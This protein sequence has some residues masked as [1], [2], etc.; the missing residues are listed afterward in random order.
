MCLI[1]CRYMQLIIFKRPKLLS[2]FL[3]VILALHQLQ[4]STSTVTSYY[5]ITVYI[6]QYMHLCI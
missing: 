2:E 3:T 5:S 6:E 1:I 4:D